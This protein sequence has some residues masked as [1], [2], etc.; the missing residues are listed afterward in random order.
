MRS[1]Q[2]ER[3]ERFLEDVDEQIS[4]RPIHAALN[5][6]LRA[7]VEDKAEVYMEYGVEEDEAYDKAIRDMGDASVIGIEM[8]AAHHIR[9]A[10]PL[11][12]SLLGL[13]CLG[14]IGNF[15][16]RGFSLWEISYNGYFLWGLI[17][18]MLVRQSKKK[19]TGISIKRGQDQ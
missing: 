13:L 11:L 6:E 4:Y 12:F 8:N 10:K 5:E 3:L 15:V 7:H 17:V 16:D 18:L 19:D 9:M 2:Q 14:V 1:E